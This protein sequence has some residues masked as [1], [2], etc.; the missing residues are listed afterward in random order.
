MVERFALL[1][2]NVTCCYNKSHAAAEA[3]AAKLRERGKE[4]FLVQFDVANESPISGRPWLPLLSTS[5]APSAS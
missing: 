2:A 4:I 3:L 1:D 5:A